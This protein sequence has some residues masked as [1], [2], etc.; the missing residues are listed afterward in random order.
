MDYLKV[1]TKIITHA[2]DEARLGNRPL[3]KSRKFNN[4]LNKKFKGKY[5][6]MHHIKPRSLFPDLEK[7]PENIVP[8][9][10][11]EHFF[12]HKLLTKIYPSTEMFYALWRMANR[13]EIKSS[14][15][16]EKVR[17]YV[18][19][20]I[21]LKSGNSNKKL[22]NNGKIEKYFYEDEV[23]DGFKKGKIKVKKIYNN[24]EIEKY[25][26]E[27]EAPADFKRGTLIKRTPE[28]TGKKCYTNG[29]TNI[30]LDENDEIPEG[31]K[32]GGCYSRKNS[33]AKKG[34]KCPTKGLK[35]FNNGIQE[36]MAEVCP[37]GFK[38]GRLNPEKYATTTG[39]SWWNNGKE[40]KLCKEKPNDDW[41]KGR[42]YYGKNKVNKTN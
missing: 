39:F 4:K 40:Q 5:F 11:K 28:N 16:Y 35:H 42:L 15:E 23:P 17:K 33:G 21:F 41:V 38:P 20:S 3:N 2:K 8:L 13:N 18:F 6:E 19:E 34:N 22:Y 9:T 37:N 25:F 32:K 12:C 10:L 30:Y 7:D 26:S 1:Y 24:G 31:F 36:V 27:D 29:K 14:K